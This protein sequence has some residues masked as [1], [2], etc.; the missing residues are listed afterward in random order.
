MNGIGCVRY[1]YNITISDNTINSAGNVTNNDL[2]RGIWCTGENNT[3]T[4]NTVSQ[5]W[6]I[7]IL[8]SGSNIISNNVI[9]NCSDYGIKIS[10]PSSNP[11]LA[12]PIITNNLIRDTNGGIS[13]D[14]GA[15]RRD[16]VKG[17]VVSGNIIKE[18][19]DGFYGIY[20]RL[21]N[22]TYS[23]NCM[24]GGTY[25]I[26]VRA[27]GCKLLGNTISN[28]VG[29]RIRI[30]D[31]GFTVYLIVTDNRIN[32]VGGDGIFMSG[33][34]YSSFMG[35]IITRC[36]DGIDETGADNYNIYLGNIVTGNSGDA[37]DINGANCK[38]PADNR[39]FFNIGTFA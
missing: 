24:D 36:I 39:S 38:P 34:T 7:G 8:C 26:Y 21:Y 11:N 15:T 16:E 3:I 10:I 35:N 30:Y 2:G 19:N 14:H 29:D 13:L 6:G 9:V 17:G 31:G 18:C 1:T 25:G 5:I 23:N 37:Y 32:D 27:S 12:N 4:G 20:A 28:T 22:I 33:V